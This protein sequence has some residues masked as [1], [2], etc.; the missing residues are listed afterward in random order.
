M[1]LRCTR[2]SSACANAPKLHAEDVEQRLLDEIK[3]APLSP[4]GGF[5]NDLTGRRVATA[6]DECIVKLSR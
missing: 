6:F 4:G 2:R 3:A 1:F 5:E